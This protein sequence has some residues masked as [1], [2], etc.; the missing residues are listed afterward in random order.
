MALK[1]IVKVTITREIPAIA[2]ASFG[3]P[4]IV[5]EFATSKTTTPFTR[6]RWY[7]DL[8]E[9]TAD[10]WLSSD[11]EY[12]KAQG[13]MKQNPKVVKFG[14]GRKDSTDAGWP[15]ALAAITSENNDWY[16]MVA[17]P[18]GVFDTDVLAI[19]GWVE[20]QRK[21]YAVQA[22]DTAMLGSGTS[23]IASQL[24]GLGYDRTI[25]IYHASS[26]AT[27][28]ADAAWI[29]EC[30]PF[31]PGSQTWA[32]KTLA[33]VTADTLSTTQRSNALGKNCNIYTVT[34][35]KSITEE[36]KV[37]SGEFIDIIIGTDWIEARL[38]EEIYSAL[39]T[40]RKLPFDDGGITAVAGLTKGVLLQGASKGILQADSISVTAPKYSEVPVADRAS[41]KLPDIKF[42]GLYQGAIH[43]VEINGTISI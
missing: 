33:G 30:F 41:R 3:Y 13:F 7:A 9:M 31:E 14:V 42:N 5:S 12:K 38:Q 27:E 19:A 32:Y 4:C 18:D 25:V 10:G 21:I 8:E 6:F 24:K 23:D 26:N 11:P 15:E 22:T 43:R 39:T 36:G 16:G 28:A 37:A 20:T 17:I 29:G 34:A 40:Q 35:V 2:R 1:D